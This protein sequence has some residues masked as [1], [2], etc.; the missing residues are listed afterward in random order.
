MDARK[1][2]PGSKVVKYGGIFLAGV[3]V[4]GKLAADDRVPTWILVGLGILLVVL[5]FLT[6]FF[7]AQQGHRAWRRRKSA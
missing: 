6:M 4:V 2:D 5:L 7:L 3:L 1:D